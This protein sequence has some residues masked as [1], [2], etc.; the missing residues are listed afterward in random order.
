MKPIL[1]CLVLSSMF[2]ANAVY[3]AHEIP[4]SAEQMTRMG[5]SVAA[6]E[7]A[8]SLVSDE[9]PGRVS[10]PP[11]QER[12]ISAPLDGLVSEVHAGT[13]DEIAAD[14]TLALIESPS[15]IGLQREFLQALTEK[16][17]VAGQLKRDRQ[18]YKEGIIAE[19]RMLET[20][21]DY[22]RSVATLDERR[23]VLQLAGMDKAAIDALTRDRKLSSALTVRASA[24]GVVLESFAVVGQ[25]VEQAEPLFRLAL[26]EPLWLELR[27]PLGRLAGIQPGAPVQLACEGA[28]ASVDLIGHDVDPASQ[29][30]LVRAEVFGA[31]SCLRPGQFVE[32]RLQLG[33]ADTLY[34]VPTNAVVRAGDKTVVFVQAPIGFLATHV[35]ELGAEAG[36]SLV[37]GKLETGAMVAVSGLAAIKGAWMGLGGDAE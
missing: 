24:G 7:G 21:G 35:E 19:R 30:V 10:I 36:Y 4:I 11:R 3:A 9:L 2:F 37:K 15:V 1:S 22:A 16:G 33:G 14:Q 23:Q 34:R 20:R 32:A 8:D 27:V 29:T 25:R 26:L 18:L 31:G 5:I 6:V 13:G 28:D 17:L 12:V